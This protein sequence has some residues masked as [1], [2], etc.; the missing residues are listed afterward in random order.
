[1]AGKM[2]LFQQEQR[3]LAIARNRWQ[4]HSEIHTGIMHSKN[5][6]ADLEP[7]LH[8]LERIRHSP[9][10]IR[11]P[12]LFD[13]S[14]NFPITDMYVELRVTQVR[15][16]GQ[17]LLLKQGKTITEEQEERYK[18]H[19]SRPLGIHQCINIPHNHRLVILGE[20]GSGKTSLMKY[21]CLEIA[22][23]KSERWLVPLFIPLRHYWL[24]KQHHPSLTLLHYSANFLLQD[25]ANEP[26]HKQF[27]LIESLL[28][29]LS[30]V[31]KEH[32]LFLLDGLDEIATNN[33]AIEAVSADIR[34]LGKNFSWV[35]TSRHTGYFGDVG[36][37][38][39]Y[40][41]VRLNQA[42]IEK[43]VSNWFANSHLDHQQTDQQRLL[44]Q[45]DANPRLRDIAGN[46]FL[47][48]LLCHIQQQ[49][50]DRSL[51]LY[52]S[53]VYESIIYLIRLQLR[54][55][56][57]NN[58]LFRETE[59]RFLA[60]FCHYL[61]TGVE[62]APLQI[63]EYGHWDSFAAPD[64][65]PDFDQHFLSSRLINSWRQGGDFHFTHLTFQEYL[66]ALHLARQPFGQVK[67]QLF[68][69]HWKM[70]Y[71]FLA[72][73]YSKQ[74]DKQNLQALFKA[75]MFPVD[76]MGI[77][78]LEAARFLIEAN[79][80]D[81][82]ELIGYDLRDTL[83]KLWADSADYVRESAGETLA[84]LSPG[85]VLAKI[86][87]LQQACGQEH[88]SGNDRYVLLHSI[89]LLGLIYDTNADELILDFL[90]AKQGSLRAMAIETVALKNTQTLRQGVIDLYES[91]HAKHFD[92][93]CNVA[94]ETRH[95]VFIPY[96]RSYLQSK[97]VEMEQYGLLFRAL[98]TLGDAAIAADLLQ[99]ANNFTVEEL[100]DDLIG[101]ILALHTQAS[102]AWLVR[103]LQQTPEGESRKNLLLHAIR[104][105]FLASAAL[106]GVLE[107]SKP[108]YQ[109]VY[110]T[111][112]LEQVQK[113]GRLERV[114]MQV[115]LKI[116]TEGSSHSTGAL[117]VLEQAGAEALMNPHELKQLKALCRGYIT[118][119]DV[120]LVA[121]SIAILSRFR[122]IRAYPKIRQ[123]AIS[124]TVHGI[125]S[126]AIQALRHYI[127]LY[128]KEIRELL[129]TLYL[130]FRHH[131]Q[132]VANAALT[133]LASMD[134]R[135]I[136]RYLEN[137][138]TRGAISAFCAKEGVLLFEDSY[139]DNF[140]IRHAF[141]VLPVKLDPDIPA[142]D[143]LEVLRQACLYALENNIVQKTAA[144]RN[145]PV[146]ALFIKPEPGVN[147]NRFQHGVN[148]KTGN[149]L[150][151]GKIISAVSAQKIMNR[152]QKIC[153]AFFFG[154]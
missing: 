27:E 115:L 63:F 126:I 136:F 107:A 3:L 102:S 6:I 132:M 50:A 35:L 46:P 48:T 57:K 37:N 150:L 104:Y 1:M 75:V 137:P 86:I 128:G 96:L 111:A 123:L 84:L 56:K 47:L 21:L 138:D 22:S 15:R 71:R 118:H 76:R 125:Q 144:N 4:N 88:A 134:V 65:P 20:P 28:R 7:L 79:I 149:K 153:P 34:L 154:P 152:L 74:A 12:P 61:Y 58:R 78:N 5:T 97:P 16:L 81:S 64:M 41:V 60:G 59:L 93:L 10:F 55:V 8:L 30:G 127:S 147:E 18:Q 142:A 130:Q 2:E 148:L 116:A 72:G 19:L 70:V 14:E 29:L 23:G 131:N 67:Q 119:A 114:V 121:S 98:A 140:G 11:L 43:L 94:T 124:G 31:E 109:D 44:N 110:L 108:E 85:Y 113:G 87:S 82:T 100:S 139:I 135:D 106:T 120:E 77:L 129:H 146:P 40:E 95:Q 62:N 49:F 54:H 66:I 105:G 145:S 103:M 122:D 69:P 25:T 99:F 39:C 91:D 101:A 73:I 13:A 141:N 90:Q 17:P 80:E 38:I 51:P 53:D 112:L 133:V 26:T 117:S 42:G 9:D 151:N 89:R 32:I 45:I 143:Q 83:W 36:E 52:R 68:N 92:L 24:E 33:Q